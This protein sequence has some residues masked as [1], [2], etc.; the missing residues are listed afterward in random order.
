MCASAAA[1]ASACGRR[2]ADSSS[3]LYRS[4][5]AS[6]HS[7]PLA[8]VAT[9]ATSPSGSEVQ[10]HGSGVPLTSAVATSVTK[11]GSAAVT[12]MSAEVYLT[13]KGC[14]TTFRHL[15]EASC[16]VR[17]VASFARRPQE[18]SVLPRRRYRFALA[19]R[20]EVHLA[21]R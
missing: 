12:N 4:D 10:P 11:S 13:Q 15:S 7:P 14:A 21:R 5:P 2:S 1:V 18:E 17:E 8:S 16:N 6:S 19:A 3:R 20:W 9:R